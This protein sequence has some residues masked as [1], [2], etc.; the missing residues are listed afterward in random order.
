MSGQNIAEIVMYAFVPL[1][2][3]FNLIVYMSLKVRIAKNARRANLGWCQAAVKAWKSKGEIRREITAT[4][5]TF[6]RVNRPNGS[7]YR[8]LTSTLGSR[9][10]SIG[11]YGAAGVV[12]CVPRL[13]EEMVALSI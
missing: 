1:Q 11:D 9:S 5:S 6:G 4:R 3:F 7:P 8:A 13:T 2:G 10:A 12:R